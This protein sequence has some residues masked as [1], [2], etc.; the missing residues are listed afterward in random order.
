MHNDRLPSASLSLSKMISKMQNL[1]SSPEP[2]ERWRPPLRAF[3][4]AGCS[5]DLP[6]AAASLKTSASH[7]LGSPHLIKL[8]KHSCL[9][10]AFNVSLLC[11]AL[12]SVTSAREE[13]KQLRAHQQLSLRHRFRSPRFTHRSLSAPQIDFSPRNFARSPQIHPRNL[14][15]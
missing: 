14:P 6:K 2:S 8:V 13:K 5:S 11:S 1:K 4:S 3:P 10:R 12:L 15:S 9:A 7:P